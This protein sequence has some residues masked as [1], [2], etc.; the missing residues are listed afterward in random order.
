M[1]SA[2]M[3]DGTVKLDSIHTTRNTLTN[4]LKRWR[5]NRD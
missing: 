1:T 4:V 5:I 3:N 2:T